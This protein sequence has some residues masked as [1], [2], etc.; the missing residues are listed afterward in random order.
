MNNVP[1]YDFHIHT[2]YL[3]CADSSMELAAIVAECERLGITALGI[4]DHLNSIDRLDR[5]QLIRRDIEALDTEVA[6][7]FGAE[8][9]FSGPDGS[10]A[11]NAEIKEQYG[12][13]FASAGI[14]STYLDSYD[15]PRMLAIQHRHHLKVCRDPLVDV[16]VHPY[17]FMESE[18]KRKGWALF[19]SM[20][21]VPQ[22]YIRE[23]GQAAR[24]TGTAIEIN[25]CSNLTNPFYGQR[26]VEEYIAFLAALAAEGVCFA[27][28]SDA[29]EIGELASIRRA[30]EVAAQLNLKAAQIWRPAGRPLGGN[31]PT[32][33]APAT[34]SL[35]VQARDN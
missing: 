18:F 28:G 29:H 12:F 7:Y 5:H 4:S 16:L 27:L 20:R 30:W 17:W 13:Q 19:D 8:L 32:T 35:P 2:K 23:L 1:W 25:A 22:S 31:Q 9:N 3:G 26:Y 15:L 34:P 24:E 11:F 21:A 6:V 14:H 10:F 33:P